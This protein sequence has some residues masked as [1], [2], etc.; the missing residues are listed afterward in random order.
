MVASAQHVGIGGV[1]NF[2]STAGYAADGGV[3]VQCGSVFDAAVG[4]IAMI[5]ME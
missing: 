4:N 2:D 3:A 5:P 1:A